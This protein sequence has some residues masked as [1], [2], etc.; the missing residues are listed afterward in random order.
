MKGIHV[1]KIYIWTVIVFNRTTNILYFA[2][3]MGKSEQQLQKDM[4]TER[5]TGGHTFIILLNVYEN[6]YIALKFLSLKNFQKF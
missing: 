4:C 6:H 3:F 5:H 1:Y 2:I